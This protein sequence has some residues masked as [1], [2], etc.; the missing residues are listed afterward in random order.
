MIVYQSPCLLES[1]VMKL[2]AVDPRLTASIEEKHLA[3]AGIDMSRYLRDV[4]V[5]N[6]KDAVGIASRLSGGDLDGDIG[7]VVWDEDLVNDMP[8]ENLD[9]PSQEDEL[10]TSKILIG[11]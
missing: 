10:F 11:E 8:D 3:E 1:D 5:L 4:I 2:R 9:P 7:V 6:R